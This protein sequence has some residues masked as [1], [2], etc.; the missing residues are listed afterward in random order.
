[1]EPTYNE[2]CNYGYEMPA[3]YGEWGIDEDIEDCLPE[4]GKLTHEVS[5]GGPAFVR[6][7]SFSLIEE[8]DIAQ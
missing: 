6:G 5:T 8:D 7:T 1:M 3:E 2:D 4:P